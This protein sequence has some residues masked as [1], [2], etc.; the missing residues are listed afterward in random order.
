MGL[1]NAEIIAS[2]AL[3]QFVF[4]GQRIFGDYWT[5]S[6]LF[7]SAFFLGLYLVGMFFFHLTFSYSRKLKGCF[8]DAIKQIKVFIPFL[9][10]FFLLSL[11]AD[12]IQF[13]PDN[14]IFEEGSWLGDAALLILTGIF[15]ILNMIFLPKLIKKF[16][17]C[18]PLQD[19][20]LK[21]KLEIICKRADFKHGGLLTWPVMNPSLT[22]AILGVNSK[23]RYVVFTPSLLNEFP[24]EEIEAILAHEIGHSKHKHLIIYPFILLGMVVLFGLF[25]YLL[26]DS[27]IEFF[28]QAYTLYPSRIWETLFPLV[29]VLSFGLIGWI[30]YRLVF[31]YFSRLF[32]R[33]ADLYVYNVGMSA[34]PMIAALDH[35]GTA[36]G[37]THHHPSWHHHSIK[38]R[39]DFLKYVESHPEAIMAHNR[40]IKISLLIY[41]LTFF[42][43][44][45]YLFGL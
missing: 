33:Q 44:V 38:E 31:G 27:L 3:F 23:F 21:T 9:I 35:L 37:N 14:L 45:F 6:Y 41:T 16:W 2:I 1:A 32:E 24:D 7:N 17:E 20:P 13:L 39:I 4:G 15:L 26:S 43:L 19:S 12:F 5:H 25:S 8:R 42:F 18:R 29:M 11:I 10:P 40:K 22:A 30:Y 28:L 36:T 34:L